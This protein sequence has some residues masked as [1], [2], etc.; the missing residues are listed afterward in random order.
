MKCLRCFFDLEQRC[1]SRMFLYRNVS[2]LLWGVMLCYELWQLESTEGTSN[3]KLTKKHHDS[4]KS[5]STMFSHKSL[6]PAEFLWM[7]QTY[8]T[9]SNQWKKP[10]HMGWNHVTSDVT[11]Q[12]IHSFTLNYVNIV[13]LIHGFCWF[14]FCVVAKACPKAVASREVVGFGGL[15][16]QESQKVTIGNYWNSNINSFTSSTPS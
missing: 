12:S 7:I 1:F 4:I 15:L 3:T 16:L 9:T 11:I 8:S 6:E 2:M 13:S 10:N 5:K 14:G